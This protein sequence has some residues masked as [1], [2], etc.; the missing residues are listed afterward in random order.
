MDTN[1]IDNIN[2]AEYLLKLVTLL[3]NH[4]HTESVPHYLQFIYENDDDEISIE[5]EGFFEDSDEEYETN[6]YFP[7]ANKVFKEKIFTIKEESYYNKCCELV[8]GNDDDFCGKFNTKYYRDAYNNIE[9][10]FYE[11]IDNTSDGF[12]SFFTNVFKEIVY[13]EYNKII[14]MLSNRAN[15]IIKKYP[16]VDKSNCNGNCYICTE[17]LNKK[18]S[19]KPPCGHIVHR[20]CLK[21]CLLTSTL[22]PICRTEL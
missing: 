18:I 2:D 14:K 9:D 4:V 3:N 5:S 22:C 21:T 12:V 6:D 15:K 19:V 8:M 10:N 13:T 7:Q 17:K 20:Q 11:Y 1:G 16:K